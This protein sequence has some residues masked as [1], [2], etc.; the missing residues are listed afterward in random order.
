MKIVLKFH[1]PT[2]ILSEKQAVKERYDRAGLDRFI[3]LN[4]FIDSASPEMV[5]KMCIN[6]FRIFFKGFFELFECQR[7]DP[8]MTAYIWVTLHSYSF[9]IHGPFPQ[10]SR[11][12]PPLGALRCVPF[13]FLHTEKSF[14]N[15]IK[16]TRNQ[17]VFTIFRLIWNQTDVRLVPN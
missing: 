8:Y 14:R 4:R 16:S 12:P 10:G 15:L 3:V 2:F 11:S 17:I 9:Y 7:G 5:I 1:I 13:R 6:F